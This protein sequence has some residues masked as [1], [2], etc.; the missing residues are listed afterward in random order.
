MRSLVTAGLSLLV[1][2]C[3]ARHAPATQPGPQIP[4]DDSFLAA[5]LSWT[6]QGSR[7]E[8]FEALVAAFEHV[9]VEHQDRT[10]GEVVSS[11]HYFAVDATTTTTGTQTRTQTVYAPDGGMVR[12]D[13]KTPTVTVEHATLTQ[14]VQ[15]WF[16][17]EGDESQ[18]TMSAYRWRA[19]NGGEP[20][21]ALQ[22][23]GIEWSEHHLF[24]PLRRAVESKIGEGGTPTEPVSRGS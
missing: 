10:T 7:S 24:L 6:F 16:R 20:M 9:G 13:T 19:W 21:T 5:H 23:A 18:C 15:Y 3:A 14:S 17:V 4:I 8:C 11:R 1:C 12:V 2:G 22:A